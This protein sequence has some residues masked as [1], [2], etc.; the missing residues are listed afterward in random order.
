[1]GN[2]TLDKG[3]WV[4][5]SLAADKSNLKLYI[6][7]KEHLSWDIPDAKR[8]HMIDGRDTLQIHGGIQWYHEAFVNFN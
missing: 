2:F 6:G 5:I 1:M 3:S 8:A 4:H 7:G